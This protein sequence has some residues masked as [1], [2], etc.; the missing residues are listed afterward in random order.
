MTKNLIFL[1]TFQAQASRDE[2]GGVLRRPERSLPQHAAPTAA[3][4]TGAPLTVP[5]A[6][7]FCVGDASG[8]ASSTTT[9]LPTPA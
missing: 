7:V 6:G 3:H 2:P 4:P 8:T 9:V 5:H 1:Y